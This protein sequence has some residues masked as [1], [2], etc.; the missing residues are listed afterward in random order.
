[1]GLKF[2]GRGGKKE[3]NNRGEHMMVVRGGG[4]EEG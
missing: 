2:K 1:M 4:K 3:G